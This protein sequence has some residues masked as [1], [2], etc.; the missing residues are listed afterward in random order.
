M[1]GDDRR[2]LAIGDAISRVLPR[3][4][5]PTAMQ[6]LPEPGRRP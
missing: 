4:Q 5:P 3:I 2:V 6:P 1:P